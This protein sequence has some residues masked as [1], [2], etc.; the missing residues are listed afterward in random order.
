MDHRKW[1]AAG[2]MPVDGSSC[3]TAL[4]WDVSLRFVQTT[5]D[6]KVFCCYEPH[7]NSYRNLRAGSHDERCCCRTLRSFAFDMRNKGSRTS[8]SA[9]D[10]FLLN[11]TSIDI[12]KMKKQQNYINSVCLVS[13]QY[14]ILIVGKDVGQSSYCLF[15]LGLN[16][17]G[18]SF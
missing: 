7:K 2:S 9:P 8:T 4:N 17:K 11:L 12:V 18:R 10:V 5:F 15:H 3:S 13:I 1:R 16:L 14:L 6:R